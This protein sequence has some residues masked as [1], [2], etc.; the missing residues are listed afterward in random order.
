MAT[1]AAALMLVS[2]V[3]SAQG[4]TP[5]QGVTDKEILIAGFGPMTGPASWAG[6]GNRDGFTLAIEEINKAGGINGR[7]I[8]FVF[9]DDASQ[10]AR[11][12]TVIRRIL[13]EIKPFMVFSGTNSVV[14]TSVADTLR[15]AKIPVYNGFSGSV[16][17]RKKPEAPYLF[18]GQAVPSTAYVV[19]LEK[20][21]TEIGAKR[22]AILHDLHEWGRSLC[23]PSIEMLK[24]KGTPAVVVQTYKFGDTDFSGQLV[25]IRNA[26]PQ[27]VINCGS[28]PEAAIILK[29]AREIGVKSLFIGDAAQANASVW[30]R[31]G[32]GA[33]NFIFNWFSPAFLSDETGPM[34]PFRAK[35]KARYPD[36]PAGRPNHGDAFAY[37]DA[38]IIAK[39]LKDAGPDLTPDSFAA[40]LKNIKNFQPTPITGF[41]N[42]DNPGHEG[43]LKSVWILVQ[44]GKTQV[45]GAPQ[46]KTIAGMVGAL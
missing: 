39:A 33:D 24:K 26:N 17:A 5:V 1:F 29:Q 14:F 13:T 44:D 46:L 43:F 6:L 32:K 18:H 35:Y 21:L 20:L 8:K 30:A 42:F 34:V 15:E 4:K 31:A 11:A 36:A 38:Y 41:G 37:G 16:A 22:V 25:A 7:Q 2:A 28:Y 12:Q 40:A 9:E 3:A 23:E 10:V 19:D 27:V 45:I